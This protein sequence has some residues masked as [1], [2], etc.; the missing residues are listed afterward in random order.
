[1]R[2]DKVVIGDRF[3]HDM[4]DVDALA[5]SIVDIGL[6]HPIV[7]TPDNKLIAGR[8]RLE[9]FKLLG[10]VDIPATVVDLQEI[11][12][13]EFAENEIR[14]DFTWSERCAIADALEPKERDAAKEREQVSRNRSGKLPAP[15]GQALDKVATAVGA[16]RHTLEKARE[17]YES[18]DES[19]IAEMDRT[20]KVTGPYRELKRRKDA[21]HLAAIP[22]PEG[23]YRT[24]VID[25]PWDWGDENDVSQ[26]GRSKPT[27]STIPLSDLERLPIP[28]LSMDDCHLY[29]WITN[30]SLYKGFDLLDRWGFRYITMLTWCKPSIGIGNYFRNNTEHILFAVKGSMRLLRFDVGTWFQA[31]RGS[32]HSSK[33]QEAYDVIE[34]CSPAPRLDMFA[35]EQRE[36]FTAWGNVND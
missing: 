1:M 16:S 18:G 22:S 21:E 9:A 14:K 2:I 34:S 5:E 24:I 19:L 27:Y 3:R 10:L 23:K 31:A 15:K 17:I 36:G 7:V 4:G 25:P 12:R 35:R 33:P 30:R 26:M 28:D 11:A 6:L 13:G 8:R 29:L 20:D 32:E